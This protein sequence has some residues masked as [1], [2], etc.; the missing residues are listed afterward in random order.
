MSQLDFIGDLPPPRPFKD[1]RPTRSSSAEEKAQLLLELGR[2]CQTP[3]PTRPQWIDQP[4][5][6][7][8]CLPED[9]QGVVRE[10]PGLLGSAW[11][12]HHEHAPLPGEGMTTPEL[13][14]PQRAEPDYE[15]FDDMAT[16][17]VDHAAE[18]TQLDRAKEAPCN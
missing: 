7:V 6:G 16:Y 10:Q 4:D 17:A 15:A 1:I 14:E 2:L 13:L 18:L 8:G 3:P 12:R 9:R 5:S 11:Y